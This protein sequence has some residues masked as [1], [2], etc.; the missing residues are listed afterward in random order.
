MIYNILVFITTILFFT[1]SKNVSLSDV[2]GI[3][4]EIDNYDNELRIE[5]IMYPAENTALVRID[6]TFS[7]DETQLYNCEDDDGDWLLSDD[8]NG[9]GVPDCGEQH[10]DEYD[11]ILPQVHI[12][13]LIC[14]SVKIIDP[15]GMIYEFDYESNAGT[16]ISYPEYTIGQD[17]TIIEE[18]G[19]WVSDIDFDLDGLESLNIEDRI[20][21]LECDCGDF[22]FITATD[23]IP[24]LVEFY[25]DSLGIIPLY[26]NIQNYPVIM[27]LIQGCEVENFWFT[28][29][30][31][32]LIS[33][34]KFY[35]QSNSLYE[36]SYWVN[37]DEFSIFNID[38][39]SC[40]PTSTNY[41]HSFPILGSTLNP[42]D[43]SSYIV[44][45]PIAEIPGFYEIKVDAM[46]S[47][48]EDYFLYNGLGLNDPVRSNLRD[49]NDDVIMGY[50]GAL[51]T[52]ILYTIVQPPPML[53]FGEFDP[54]QSTLDIWID[55]IIPI[56]SFRF[57][58]KGAVLGGDILDGELYNNPD[59]SYD[60]DIPSGQIIPVSTNSNI[61]TG[62][63]IF[64]ARI[65]LDP[66]SIL[67]GDEICIENFLASW[68]GHQLGYWVFYG[69]CIT[70][71]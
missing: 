28:T 40:E 43:E 53:Y 69:D 45:T 67:P 70:V 15:D 64:L 4:Q 29:S 9:N 11:E 50:F 52:N 49:D 6:R 38:T 61:E 44:S 31:G 65:T 36:R 22:G 1:C 23:T 68:E 56:T 2:D 58:I 26:Q 14:T 20:F 39:E 66:N 27:N 54:N 59:W 21:T 10:V 46:S 30:S 35:Y 47:G 13:S 55:A 37:I 24:L 41:I 8:E 71:D 25:E 51:T 48:F 63:N 16:L 60:I 42:P 34:Q 18:Y 33:N 32:N 62:E 19:A 17:N 12:D 5:A 3:N 7:L 57:S